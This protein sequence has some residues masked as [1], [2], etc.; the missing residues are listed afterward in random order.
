VLPQIGETW[1]GKYRIERVLG[2]GG[3]GIVFEARHLRL[4]QQVAIKCL[5][6][7]LAH[8][9]ALVAR[10]EREARAAA[11]LRTRN[12]V[13]I[14]DVETHAT[15]VPYMVM[16]MMRGRDLDVESR[17]LG[18]TIPAEQLIPWIVQ[19]A[20]A[21]YE[22]HGAGIVHRDIK[23][24]NIFIAEEPGER[25]AKLLDFGIAKAA[26]I[27]PGITY[28]Q[29]GAICGTPQYMS[30]EAVR[31]EA[32]D[33]RTDQWALGILCYEML[34]GRVPF[35]ATAFT[36]L[37]IQVVNT[38]PVPLQQ[39]R[40]DLPADLC[41]VIMR[42]IEKRVEDRYADMAGFARGLLPYCGDG[43]VTMRWA[44]T[45]MRKPA[46]SLSSSPSLPR[47][48]PSGHV[49]PPLSG[50]VDPGAATQ[51]N[52]TLIGYKAPK[53][54]PWLI[55]MGVGI[56]VGVLSGV[57]TVTYRFL[58]H[59]PTATQTMGQPAVVNGAV[60]AARSTATAINGGVTA[61]A[62]AL[63]PEGAN[64]STG[65]TRASAQVALAATSTHPNSTPRTLPGPVKTA[66][67]PLVTSPPAS[68]PTV[69]NNGPKKPADGI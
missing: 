59:P 23:P 24:S 52:S 35:D 46:L 13:K 29:V 20:G 62:S 39:L 56:T 48:D 67:V 34:S 50:A 37:A 11:R 54:S 18:G 12:V 19:V 15:G 49:S 57:G 47:L 40:P 63:T 36:A 61:P 25:V 4:E 5:L 45:G 68:V 21:L 2:E 65:T 33:G 7:A 58:S 10:F 28:T 17:E 16:E 66:V 55:T 43:E 14:L 8:D 30:P 60:I 51:F 53:R 41:A 22:A 64:S 38:V 69:K 3:M 9:Q 31:D 27:V 42:A 6:P 1:D 26:Q 44:E 32:L